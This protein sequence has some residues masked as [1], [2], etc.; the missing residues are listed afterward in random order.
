MQGREEAAPSRQAG[1]QQQNHRHNEMKET[2]PTCKEGKASSPY[3]RCQ[4]S[5][6]EYHRKQMKTED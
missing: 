6:S 2:G 4:E 1:D 3:R 5:N